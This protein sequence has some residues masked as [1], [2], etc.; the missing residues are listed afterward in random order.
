MHKLSLQCKAGGVWGGA[1]ARPKVD[2]QWSQSQDASTARDRPPPGPGIERQQDLMWSASIKIL[3]GVWLPGNSSCFSVLETGKICAPGGADTQEPC[4]WLS[5]GCIH[6]PA[7]FRTAYYTDALPGRL[8]KTVRWSL[9]SDVYF[10]EDHCR[11]RQ[12]L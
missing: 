2:S 7:F 5:I 3:R 1:P 9:M 8:K 11:S 4:T 10:P 6:W 12:F